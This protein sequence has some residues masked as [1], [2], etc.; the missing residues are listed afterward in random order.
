MSVKK[1]ERKI[2]RKAEDD[3]TI[4][5]LLRSPQLISQFE[6]QASSIINNYL[7]NKSS[8]EEGLKEEGNEGTTENER[9]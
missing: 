3:E 1:A 7:L 6:K 5:K 2:Q 4:K 9:N 8:H